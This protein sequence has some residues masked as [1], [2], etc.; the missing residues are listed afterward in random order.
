MKRKI[1]DTII[2]QNS[3]GT[4]D[5][6]PKVFELLKIKGSK[7]VYKERSGLVTTITV[8]SERTYDSYGWFS[9]GLIATWQYG[10]TCL[11]YINEYGEVVFKLPQFRPE[12]YE[13]VALGCTE[14]FPKFYDGLACFLSPETDKFGYID[15][16]GKT[17]IAPIYDN[18]K[19]FLNGRA[20]VET[21]EEVFIINKNGDTVFK[22]DCEGIDIAI[23]YTNDGQ[24]PGI[25]VDGKFGIFD[26]S[27]L[28]WQIPPILDNP[29]LV[30][31]PITWDPPFS[32]FDKTEGPIR[33]NGKYGLAS[34]LP[35]GD[36]RIVIPPILDNSPTCEIFDKHTPTYVMPLNTN[37][38]KTSFAR[39]EFS[40]PR[41]R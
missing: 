17:V 24:N 39:I 5:I 34:A 27:T 9:D 18:A 16:K 7:I 23:S 40:E 8:I 31:K 6:G 28:K 36:A 35:D 22:M 25:E 1:A 41:W 10:K 38:G 32:I 29:L 30:W 14:R 3:D 12:H 13:K 33:I 4:I 2:R 20:V 37:G 11:E 15:T 21:N 19:P 26:L